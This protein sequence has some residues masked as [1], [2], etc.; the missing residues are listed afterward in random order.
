MLGFR[1][2]FIPFGWPVPHH[3]FGAVSNK[4]KAFLLQVIVNVK[5]KLI[6]AQRAKA[7]FRHLKYIINR[8]SI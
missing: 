6:I 7:H 3:V 8:G 4:F 1:Y 5:I 2:E